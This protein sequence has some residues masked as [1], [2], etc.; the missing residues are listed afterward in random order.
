MNV[1]KLKAVAAKVGD[2]SIQTVLRWVREGSF[3]KPFHIG[4]GTTVWDEADV[5]QWLHKHKET[6]HGSSS[7]PGG[8]AEA[9]AV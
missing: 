8:K 3:P 2:V 5:D 4:G 1:L 9:Q 6:H 7:N